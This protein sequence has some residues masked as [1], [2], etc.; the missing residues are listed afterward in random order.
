MKKIGGILIALLAVFSLVA[1]GSNQANQETGTDN[2]ESNTEKEKPTIAVSIVP[3]KAW[4]ENVV[5]DFANVV[6][7]IPPGKSPANYSPS[8]K[9]LQQFSAAST[10]FSIGVPTE[11][12]N[13]LSKASDI[14]PDMTIVPL[15]E[16]ARV[17]Y[18]ERQFES[19]K[20]DQHIWL[21]PK[22][23][24]VMVQKIAD[25]LSEQ[26]PEQKEM[27]QE[28]AT[29]YLEDIQAVDQDIQTTLEQMETKKFIVY[30][31][32]FGYFADDYGLDMIAIE[33]DGKDA[34]PQR[35]QAI[36]ELAKEEDIRV[37]FYQS[38]IDSA[39]SEATAEEIGGKTVQVA[40]LAPDYV[41]NLKRM[42]NTFRDAME[43]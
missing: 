7:M 10:Y 25:A 38:E 8:P 17:E 39:Q 23:V 6:V 22:R 29:T 31:P 24:Q 12:V 28:N 16:A 1:C 21:S 27:F 42:A 34:T 15:H 11:S 43:Q 26:Y 13:I 30:H 5:G 20:R 40:P 33:K 19:G 14:N 35:L 37:I 9:E 36:I 3:E 2:T 32:A 41:D 18:P 4:V